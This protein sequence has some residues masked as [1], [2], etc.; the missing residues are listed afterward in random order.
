VVEVAQEVAQQS[1]AR[2][3]IENNTQVLVW[4]LGGTPRTH[5]RGTGRR[6]RREG[7]KERRRE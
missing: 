7:E 3:R 6:R 2:I 1:K 5:R 4:G